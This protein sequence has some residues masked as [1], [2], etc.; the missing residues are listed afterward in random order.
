M[1]ASGSSGLV[2]PWQEP[3]AFGRRL[4]WSPTLS[5]FSLRGVAK[6]TFSDSVAFD[7]G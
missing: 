1:T 3:T 5:P 2:P 6:C 4:R 7:S